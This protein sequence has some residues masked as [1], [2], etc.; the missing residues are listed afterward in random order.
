MHRILLTTTAMACAATVASAA[1]IE[2]TAN[3]YSVLYEEGDYLKFGVSRAITD[4][5]GSYSAAF[6]P[7]EGTS[8]GDMSQDYTALSFGYK[9]QLTDKWALGIFVNQPY[10]ADALYTDGPYAGLTAEWNSV[11]VT[12]L[13]K[14]QATDRVSVYGGA[15]V[16]KSDATI[17]IPSALTGGGVYEASTSSE[18][19]TSFI[20]GSAYEIPEI[21][22]RVGL[23]YESGSTYDFQSRESSGGASIDFLGDGQFEIE[24]PQSLT[25]NFQSGVAEDTLVFGSVR[26]AE[27]SVWEV[28]PDAYAAANGGDRVTGIDNNSLA[29][30]L[31]VGR[32]INDNLSVF[33]QVGWERA[34]GGEAS[35]LAP[36]DGQRSISIGANW[37]QDAYDIT[38]GVSYIDL[39]DAVD[40]AGVDFSGNSAIGVGVSV[41]YKF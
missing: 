36:T 2:R 14:Y 1:G 16:A 40:S 8:T 3:D 12:A 24:M 28:R 15:R 32:R 18:I 39:G 4:V 13:G 41:G 10:G 19:A 20:L 37:E 22:L 17:S 29:A 7:F 11:G 27:W 30:T 26:W 5:S 34:S 6:G 21:A 25:L 35:R 38:A 23:T 9:N 33:G 31:G